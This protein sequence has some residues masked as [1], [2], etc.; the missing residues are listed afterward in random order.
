MFRIFPL[1]LSMLFACL[2]HSQSPI[3]KEIKS[4]SH[5]LS[6][7]KTIKPFKIVEKK[8]P[9]GFTKILNGAYATLTLDNS[10]NESVIKSSDDFLK[11]SIPKNKKETLTL[12]LERKDIFSPDFQFVTSVPE[13]NPINVM[14]AK[15][16][17]GYVEG[18]P[19]SL[20]VFNVFNDEVSATINLGT[21]KFTLA[22]SLK[23]A[24]HFL[25][26]ESDL[27]EQPILD[28]HTDELDEIVQAKTLSSKSAIGV[29]NC[30]RLHIEIDYDLYSQV[31]DVERIGNYVAG[32]FSEVIALYAIEAINMSVSYIKVWNVPD[33]FTGPD[34]ATFLNQFTNVMN[35]TPVF[36]DLAHLVGLRGGGGIA[37]LGGLCTSTRFTGYS[38]IHLFYDQVPNYSWTV[39]ILAHE[40]GHNLGSPHTH[41]C[42]WN[43][44]GTQIDDCG[45]VASTSPSHCFD[46]FNPIIPQEGG[47]IMSYCHLVSQGVDLS[48]GFGQQ[49][50]DLMRF[51]VY[52]LP[53][54]TACQSSCDNEGQA[55]DDRDPCTIDDRFNSACECSGTPV[56]DNDGDGYC[57]TVDPDDT[58][59]CNPVA[60]NSSCTT[61]TILLN[62]DSFPEETTC[63]I[64]NSSGRLIYNIAF[65]QAFQTY[66][67]EMCLADDCYEFTMLDAGGNGMC[68]DFGSGSFSV[69]GKN[70]QV[71][72][73]GGSFQS[74]FSQD[75][76]LSNVAVA[77]CGPG[78][79]CDDNDA[80]TVNDVYDQN[81]N[82]QG[83]FADNDNDGICNAND[84]CHG[85][86]DRIDSDRDGIPDACDSCSVSGRACDDRNPC[87]TNDTY[88]S[89]CQCAGTIADADGDGVCDAEDVCSSGD[90]RVD[91][92]RDGIPD[93][94]DNCSIAGQACNDNDPCTIDDIYDNACN[95]S[96]TFMDTDGDGICDALDHGV[97]ET[98][99]DNDAV[100]NC[101]ELS[102]DDFENGI[103]KWID[104][105][106]DA[107][108]IQNS[109]KS[110][111]GQFVYR[112]RDNTGVN[113][114]IIYTIPNVSGTLSVEF[115]CL[116]ES[117]E[118]GEDF[119][120]EVDRGSGYEEVK[121][122]V[123]DL[124]FTN[125]V[126]FN[127][128]VLI[129][130]LDSESIS[131]RIRCDASTNSDIIYIDDIVVEQCQDTFDSDCSVGTACDDNDPC[132]VGDFYDADC[133]CVSG[134]I[135]DRDNDGFCSVIDS[136]DN[137]PCIPNDSGCEEPQEGPCTDLFFS[138]FENG[139][140][141]WSFGGSDAML[142]SSTHIPS[143]GSSAIRLRDD[144]QH[145]SSI[146]SRFMDLSQAE[147]LQV[148]FDYHA[149]SFESGE[150]FMLE[151]SNDGGSSYSLINTWTVNVDFNNTSTQQVSETIPSSLLS[152]STFI[153]IRC[154]AN[155]D[156]DHLF[157]DNISLTECRA[158][159]AESNEGE[160]R[161]RNF[162]GEGY[163]NPLI[164][165]EGSEAYYY[166]I[167]PN[168]VLDVL[169]IQTNDDD[170]MMR[171]YDI[172]GK[173][174][175]VISPNV[176][177]DL[178]ELSVGMYFIHIRSENAER[179]ERFIKM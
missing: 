3:T 121:V 40:V 38:A 104:G 30:V 34:T 16:Y 173:L 178:S 158:A 179:V 92:D 166:N 26:K 127:E 70:N 177:S 10:F 77:T 144:S 25:Y 59:D 120:L 33:P 9:T 174:M 126:R 18:H 13:K 71:L 75:F 6:D 22:K 141:P 114:S 139:I 21:E 52:N 69:I 152:N 110:N 14:D 49:P 105:G 111:S 50:G 156:L 140:L 89:N 101:A 42:S 94:C 19:N 145:A 124:D 66:E 29:D 167:F 151:V 5:L 88:D 154:N 36:G 138:D 134:T 65:N 148:N 39:N 91:T 129:N 68:C 162:K 31:N 80:C 4:K 172:S 43:G 58:D 176:K 117:M 130:G 107:K 118:T 125:L 113:S 60:C 131:I 72:I 122:W 90:D 32:A 63:Q 67:Q 163:H 8:A 99:N 54:L 85:G 103:G 123:S 73:S 157:I 87:T 62:F 53:C 44:N 64:R 142:I 96:G 170:V 61:I 79:P 133:L 175:R 160:Q 98:D 97:I 84:S 116:P 17:W 23:S 55:C 159:F 95:C 155:S 146:Y 143:F 128:T 108:L 150:E 45:N 169:T 93:A 102:R 35:R 132:T 168:P 109:N 76:C 86:D 161:T 48:L 106:A 46:R 147:S 12:V 164:K 74:T 1:V 136:D 11:L 57:Q 100:E 119:M 37:F 137:D 149:V 41:S 115:S 153:R 2:L 51:R 27:T 78:A 83:V 24:D 135:I 7:I 56:P 47:T 171:I 165:L 28:C 82:C 112:L 20:V 15:F 81:C